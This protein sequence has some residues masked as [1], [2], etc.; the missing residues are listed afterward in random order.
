MERLT[1]ETKVL[2]KNDECAEANRRLFEQ[3]GIAVANFMSAP[4]AGKTSVLEKTLGALKRDFQMAVIEGDLY[5]TFDADRIEATGV[6]AYQITTGTCCHLDARMI[7]RVMAEFHIVEPDLLVIENV[8][9]LVC[10]AEF[11]LGEDLRVMVY[12]AW[13]AE[14]SRRNIRSCS[15]LPMPFC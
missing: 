13:K 14:R 10:P 5:T 11:D 12:S 6:P 9:N 4:G 15:R 2:H 7:A 3:H 8:G 1:L